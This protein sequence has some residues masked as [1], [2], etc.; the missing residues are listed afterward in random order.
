[1]PV[2]WNLVVAWNNDVDDAW[3]VLA[4]NTDV[5]SMITAMSCRFVVVDIEPIKCH[6]VLTSVIWFPHEELRLIK[7]KLIEVLRCGKPWLTLHN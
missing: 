1:M 4:W 3:I 2:S 6:L 5:T 7:P